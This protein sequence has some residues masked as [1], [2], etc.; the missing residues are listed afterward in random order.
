MAKATILIVEDNPDIS[1]VI[2]DALRFADFGTLQAYNAVQGLQ[3]ASEHRP[4][5]IL[6]DIQ[7]P[8]LDGLSA[9]ETLKQDPVTQR[10]PIVAMTAYDV[11]DDRPGPPTLPSRRKAYHNPF[12]KSAQT[13]R[14]WRAFSP[15]APRVCG[16]GARRAATRSQGV[17]GTGRR[18]GPG[19]RA[20]A[21][22]HGVP[23]GVP[24]QVQP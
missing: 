2:A 7:L 14:R 4:D 18:G 16:F 17:A 21:G 12:R 20:E 6:M 13:G 3:L 11:V 19:S 1:Q 10:S 9:A 15:T 22:I 24:E 5:L 23:D 8:D